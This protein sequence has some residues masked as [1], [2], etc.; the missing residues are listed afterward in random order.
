MDRKS[1]GPLKG[2]RGLD[3]S[4]KTAKGRTTTQQIWL[5]R[6]LNDPYVRAAQAQ[7]WRS[8][9]AFKLMELDDRYGLIQRGARVLDLGA[10]PGGWSQVA[11]KRG[12]GPLVG[13]DL[14][15]VEP[16]QGAQ[17]IQGDFGEPDMPDRLRAALGGPAD[18]VLS[19]MAP[20]TT[21]HTAT[22]H[23]RIVA[24]AELALDFA[25]QVL[26]PGGGFVDPVGP[27]DAGAP[28]L[29]DLLVRRDGGLDHRA[30]G[31]ASQRLSL[32]HGLGRRNLDAYL[33]RR[34]GQFCSLHCGLGRD[35]GRRAYPPRAVGSLSAL[36]LVRRAGQYMR[37]CRYGDDSGVRPGDRRWRQ[38]S[39]RGRRIKQLTLFAA[40]ESRNTA[41]ESNRRGLRMADVG[42]K[43][44]LAHLVRALAH[45]NFRLYA[46]GQG[47]SLIG[48]WMTRLALAWLT[49]RLTHSAL[50]LGLVGFAGQILTFLLA[51]FAG[52]WIDRLDRRKLLIWTQFASAAQSV[53]L[54]W[55]TLA[56]IITIPE[57]LAL[58]A[59]Q[60]L[61]DA[62]DMPAR[63]SFVV[64]MVDR[65]EDLGNAIALNSSLVNVARLIGPP[66]AAFVIAK[67]N[68]GYCFAIDGGS[69]L[70]VIVS[71]M[72]M[73]VAADAPK[74]GVRPTMLA[75]MQDGWSYVSTYVPVRNI[76]LLFAVSSLMGMSY[77]V[78]LP[79]FAT[80]VLHG[81]AH[82]LG[83]LTA[84]SGLGA[85]VAAIALAARKSVVGLVRMIE[86]ATLVFGGSVVLFGWSHSL[87]LS[88]LA[89]LGAGFGM[90]QA[91]ASSN[92]VI[93]TLVPEEKRG[94]V[95]SYYT[96]A[97][98]GMLP[99][100]S[101]LAG[102]LAHWIGAQA[103]SVA[104]G[105]C[106]LVG[107]AL[108]LLQ[109]KRVRAAMRPRYEE[110]GILEPSG[111]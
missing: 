4:L 58:A 105:I 69:Y 10:A 90:M 6:Q 77:M 86:M 26:A 91:M 111:R 78:L 79:V 1:G 22:D 87:W 41:A 88:M 83:L 2:A 9:A 110:L 67:L 28:L 54:A 44:G 3:V 7:G 60:G 17:F 72:M 82:T 92:T 74:P 13:V 38:G 70:A 23:I 21:G 66:L 75:Q 101:L 53:A 57:I 68:E 94:R 35:P 102:G 51:P 108:F 109:G 11:I 46:V 96:M 98:I 95:M 100:G 76:L 43:T 73:R 61:I 63:Q 37:R 52:V 93:Q 40:G 84:S 81:N 18:L 14:L 47:I 24:L 107:S 49:Y 99:F 15:A 65:K 71:L 25:V 20:N 19:D 80:Q 55:L 56:G 45:R 85:L 33:R 31:V 104:S 5:K 27:A 34:P 48:S 29:R 32:D 30:G 103:T 39:A 50:L 59:L 42:N 16:V 106:V 64:K 8:R 62:F 89:M 36:V 97:F 12:A